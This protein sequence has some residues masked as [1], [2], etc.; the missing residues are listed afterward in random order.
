MT[1][2]WLFSLQHRFP[3]VAAAS[4]SAVMRELACIVFIVALATVML[5]PALRGDWPVGHDH[6]V[7]VVRIAQLKQTI[8]AHGMPWAWSHRWFAGYPENVGYPIGADLY[9]LAVHAL[10]FCTLSI[11]KAYGV[12]FWLFYALYGYGIFYFARQAFRSRVVA[13]LAA[14]FLL[15]DAGNSD[16]GGW[17]WLV[18]AGVW[19]A[20][21]G[22]I[23]ALIGTARIAALLA[24]PRGRT[25]AGVAVCVGLALLCHPIHLVY[26]A[27]AVPLLCACRFYSEEHTAWR[28][29]LLLLGGA[30]LSGALIASFWLVPYF[31]AAA[32]AS[33]IGTPGPSL[34][35]LGDGIV[36]GDLFSRM[37]PLAMAFGLV[38]SL[39]L[40]KA[41]TPLVLFS[42]LMVFVCLALSSSSY[43]QLFGTEIAARAHD[44]IVFPRFLMLAKPFWY[45]A[46]AWL[47]VHCIMVAGRAGEA[48]RT[49]TA[50]AIRRAALL[51]FVAVMVAPL[52]F[53]ATRA[54]MRN[55]VLRLT[56]WNSKREDRSARVAFAEWAQTEFQNTPGF[57][58]I[59]HGMGEDGH[60]LSDLALYL[61][62]PFYKASFTPTGHFKHNIDASSPE[63]F[64]ATNVRYVLS[65]APLDREDLQLVTIFPPQLNVYEFKEWNPGPFVISEGAGEVELIKFEG[66]EIVLR[67]GAGAHGRLRLNVSYFPKGTP[68]ATMWR[69]RLPP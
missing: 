67:A 10:S 24:R 34:A 2:R 56:E 9:V 39:L 28:P 69:C 27:I 40:L 46:G 55:E 58:R 29:A 18:D 41:R 44:R 11:P 65:G 64:R 51:V 53:Q 1:T 4:R 48:T 19:T 36:A 7:H 59:A 31:S 54:F 61:P 62:Y 42:G 21:L 38:G 68:R 37:L 12:A 20:A 52:L 47:L 5:H 8:L 35:D 30:L 50:S 23:P 43:L 16:V 60:R 63:A 66:E 14:V 26:F 45:V 57:F 15:T 25:A 3:F 6:P 49:H 13:L 33:E 22:L 17:F 32:Y